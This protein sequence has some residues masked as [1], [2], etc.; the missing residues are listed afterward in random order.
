MKRAFNA[1]HLDADGMTLFT[2]VLKQSV[3][4]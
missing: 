1:K 4:N 3:L 2:S